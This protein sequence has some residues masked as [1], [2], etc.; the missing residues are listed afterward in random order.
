[1]G[2]QFPQIG[3]VSS[4]CC[5]WPILSNEGMGFLFTGIKKVTISSIAEY[6]S[7]VKKANYP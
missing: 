5:A 7:F 2:S 6:R 3:N 1:M 4:I